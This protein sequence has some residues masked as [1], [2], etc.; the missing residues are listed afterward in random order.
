MRTI[1]AHSRK[2][3]HV[4]ILYTWYHGIQSSTSSAKQI[5]Y[6]PAPCF[7]QGFLY[8]A[9][10]CCQASDAADFTCSALLL[11]PPKECG[12]DLPGT[13]V[14]G[15]VISHKAQIRW[16]IVTQG[17]RFEVCDSCVG[18]FFTVD[19]DVLSLK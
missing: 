2:S 15:I 8:I 13:A 16:R 10:N 14:R 12:I 18:F 3:L 1:D 17:T 11:A 7:L 4:V 19:V 9:R 5:T 6:A